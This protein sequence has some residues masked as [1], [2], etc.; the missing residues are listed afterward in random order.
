M[1]SAFTMKK[2][3]PVKK[4]RTRSRT[5][6]P[7]VRVAFE[8]GGTTF[9]PTDDGRRL[10]ISE[11]Q[12]IGNISLRF[13]WRNPSEDL[14]TDALA[15]DFRT[16]DAD[17]RVWRV[18]SRF[19]TELFVAHMLDI[20]AMTGTGLFHPHAD[21]GYQRAFKECLLLRDARFSSDDRFYRT[22]L[23]QQKPVDIQFRYTTIRFDVALL[24]MYL[25]PLLAKVAVR[26]RPGSLW[27]KETATSVN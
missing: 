12:I 11:G 7:I 19:T 14:L 3:K 8:T 10:E 1:L 15:C 24:Q 6:R 16:A 13:E 4:S 2:K 17:G 5:A 23:I 9:Y 18:T 25:A 27:D 21:R 26:I 20:S 22:L